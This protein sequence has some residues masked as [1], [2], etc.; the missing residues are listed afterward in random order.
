MVK[1][2]I[3]DEELEPSSMAPILEIVKTSVESVYFLDLVE[4]IEK[5]GVS[6]SILLH[7]FDEWRVIE[8]RE[9]LKLADGRSAAIDRLEEFMKT[10]ALEVQ[11]LQPLFDKH[12]WLIDPSW[13]EAD[14]QVTYTELLRKHCKEPKDL[15]EKDRRIDIF[16]MRAGGGVTV[17]ELKRPQKTLAREDLE[18][19]EKYVDWAQ[20]NI[21]GG[22]GPD[23][24]KYINGL[25]LVGHLGTGHKDKIKRLA[26]DDIRVETF[27][28]LRT[29]A[30]EYYG[31]VERR[32]ETLAPEYIRSKRSKKP[33]K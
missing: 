20:E 16:A 17:V 10:G 33:E 24:P 1:L 3:D 19:I 21:G 25:L 11:E 7:L 8:A 30:K 2:L 28:D 4:T 32:L 29:R 15:E 5:E 14:R 26:G 9:H 6:S 31:E 18:Q 13:S 23:A 27:S 22:T 12:P